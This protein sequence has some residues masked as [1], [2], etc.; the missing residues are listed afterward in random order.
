MLP[1]E[2]EPKMVESKLVEECKSCK[3]YEKKCM[4]TLLILDEG[5]FQ[6]RSIMKNKYISKDSIQ[7]E[8]KRIFET[9][10]LKS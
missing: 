8:D 5:G 9:Y 3:Y 10:E 1:Q 2:I 7:L 4:I 6:I